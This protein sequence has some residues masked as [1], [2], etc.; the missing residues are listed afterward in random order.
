MCTQN[1]SVDLKLYMVSL[2]KW[3]TCMPSETLFEKVQLETVNSGLNHKHEKRKKNRMLMELIK[4][5]LCLYLATK[6]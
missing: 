3:T 5:M 2:V 6:Y 4:H 1:P